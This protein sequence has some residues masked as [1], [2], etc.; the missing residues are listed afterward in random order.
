MTTQSPAGAAAA[1]AAGEGA[2]P[3]VPVQPGPRRSF[4]C[5]AG[6]LAGC[7]W[8]VPR[9]QVAVGRGSSRCQ[10]GPAAAGAGLPDAASA[11]VI[12]AGP[13]AVWVG[14]DGQR[15]RRCRR[16]SILQ[17]YPVPPRS[18]AGR[19][20]CLF[21]GGVLSAAA[22]R[23]LVPRLTRFVA[24]APPTMLPRGC[25]SPV[26]CVAALA[27][28]QRHP[29]CRCLPRVRWQSPWRV[30]GP[31]PFRKHVLGSVVAAIRGGTAV[32]A[33]AGRSAP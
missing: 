30:R 8:Y 29:P 27:D 12:A 25:R 19:L 4:R 20:R 23:R 14:R 33:A 3:P 28:S 2:T 11:A 9:V 10:P 16:R 17:Q 13:C 22:G 21:P 7:R 31:F 32:L 18:Q 26:S 5:A 6:I 15:A 1:A 24:G